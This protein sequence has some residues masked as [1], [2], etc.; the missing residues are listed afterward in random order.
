MGFFFN[1]MNEDLSDCSF[2]EGDIQKCPFLR[3]INKPTSFSFSAVNFPMPVSY[4]LCRV[5]CLPWWSLL[6]KCWWEFVYAKNCYCRCGLDFEL[7]LL[8]VRGAKGPIFEDGPN[9]STAFKLFHGKNGVVPL[10]ERSS[11]YNDNELEPASQFNPLAAK[12]ATI[13]LST[14]GLGGPF[15]FGPFN[16]KWK[17]KQQKKSEAPNKRDTSSQVDMFFGKFSIIV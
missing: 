12:A 4:H 16:D 17:K 13:S 10:S 6:F 1:G 9:F 5:F 11:F 8:Q 3:N 2:N 7:L 14:F 15:S